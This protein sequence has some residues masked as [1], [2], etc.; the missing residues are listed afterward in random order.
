MIF[1]ITPIYA[2]L[3]TLLLIFL[4]AQ[5]IIYRRRNRLSLGDEGDRRLLR[6]MRAHGNCAEYAPLGLI[7]LALVEAKAA[8]AIAVHL[9]GL[10]LLAGRVIHA[11]GFS[12]ENLI[13][14]LR[15]FGMVLTFTMLGLSAIGLLAHALL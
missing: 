3:L 14:R 6:L 11:I 5:V 13:M 8:P 15:V 9:L 2:A 1:S 10:L 12:G 7:L 4:S